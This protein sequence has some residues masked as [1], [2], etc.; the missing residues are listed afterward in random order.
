MRNLGGDRK[1]GT[2]EDRKEMG[3]AEARDATLMEDEAGQVDSTGLLRVF[4]L[5]AAG[6]HEMRQCPEGTPSSAST[7]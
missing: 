2:S 3:L 5:T 1:Q 4:V 7:H 6:D